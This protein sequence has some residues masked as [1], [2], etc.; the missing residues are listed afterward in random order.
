MPE[1]RDRNKT[2]LSDAV[3]QLWAISCKVRGVGELIGHQRNET[4]PLEHEEAI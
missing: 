3:G 1:N 2:A 4:F